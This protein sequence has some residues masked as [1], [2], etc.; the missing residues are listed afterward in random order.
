[1][2]QFEK[3]LINMEKNLSELK[4]DQEKF[5]LN[6]EKRFYLKQKKKFF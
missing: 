3:M 1:M 6:F 4:R 5:N 2:N